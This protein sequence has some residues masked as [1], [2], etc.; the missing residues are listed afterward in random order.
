M[1]SNFLFTMK[2]S[3]LCVPF[4]KLLMW[5][6]TFL[7]PFFF[8]LVFFFL[9]NCSYIS[10]FF[11]WGIFL[12]ECEISSFFFID[13]LS[14]FFIIIVSVV[15]LAVLFYSLN[16][17]GTFLMK[18][19]FILSL[20]LFVLSMFLLV[21]SSDLFWIMV[22]WDGLGL[23]SLY[24]IMFFQNWKSFNSSMITFILNRLGDSFIL[25]SL[26]W[27]LSIGLSKSFSLNSSFF[28]FFLLIGALSKSAQ[29][30]FSAWLPL[31]MAA[32]TPV[33]SL[34][35]SSTLVTAGI[36]LMIR[37]NSFFNE[38]QMN[39]VFLISSISIF[40][41]GVSSIGEYD[42]KK[43]IALSTLSHIGMMVMFVSSGFFLSALVHMFTHAMF[44]SLLFMISGILIHNFQNN[45]DIRNIGFNS[46]DFMSGVSFVVSLM[47]MIGIPF[48]SGFF[49]KEFFLMISSSSN[50]F[51]LF[52]MFLFSA[53]ITASYSIRMMSHLF[54][55]EGMSFF[56]F[57]YNS[58][59]VFFFMSLMALLSG[60]MV[61]SLSE[62]SMFELGYSLMFINMKAKIFIFLILGISLGFLFSF[63]Q[64]NLP[65]WLIKWANSMWFIHSFT[66]FHQRFLFG[67]SF[68][69]WSKY[70]SKG[71]LDQLFFS[72]KKISWVF[73]LSSFKLFVPSS[74]FLISFP[75]L[76]ILPVIF[77]W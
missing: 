52:F 54:S 35:H 55:G 62:F 63:I 4:S 60:S 28:F 51:V 44:K 33:S 11:N 59:S 34:V 42:L 38:W 70:D 21:L 45:Q 43:I 10:F 26:I 3:L 61:V 18:K 13:M 69:L 2:K 67:V 46:F 40:L 27:S 64:G 39:V 20:S 22:G 32:P 68:S 25:I 77:F 57:H 19:K 9:L 15:S 53:S 30:P 14:V 71:M 48:F 24:L 72:Y 76:I 75:I 36:Y 73:S 37:F 65:F 50:K 7:F 58:G 23:T 29:F 6:S 31:A 8:L 12:M 74:L 1:K 49:S 16:Y 17:M 66:H 56:V 41:A 5:S 47:S